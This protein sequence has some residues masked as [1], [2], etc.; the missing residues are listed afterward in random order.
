MGNAIQNLWAELQIFF[1]N[2]NAR[3]GKAF[4]GIVL[5]LIASALFYLLVRSALAGRRGRRS[6]SP[7]RTRTADPETTEHAAE[8]LA[9][10]LRCP[11]ITGREE[12][13]LAVGRILQE[14]YPLVA[15]TMDWATLPGGSIFLRWQGSEAAEHRPALMCAHLDVV[16]G[17]EG[18][19]A[20]EPF[21]GVR[22]NGRVYGRGAADCKGVIV[23]QMEAVQRLM[24]EGFRPRRDIYFAFGC[25][26]E[27]GGEK[28]AQAIARRME[29]MGLTFDLVLDEGGAIR[30]TALSHGG[31]Y[32]AAYI[33][34]GEKRRCEYRLTASCPGGHS[35][36]PGKRTVLVV[37]SE[38]ICRIEAAQ[39]RHHLIPIVREHLEAAM[40]TYPFHKRM[41]VANGLLLKLIGGRVFRDDPYVSALI[42]STIVPTKVDGGFTA[43]HVLP[44]T[45]GALLNARLL[46]GEQPEKILEELR[47][48]LA[49]LPVQVELI[50][51]GEES[52]ITSEKEPMYQLLCR[53]MDELYPRLQRVPTLVTGA[54]DARH[55]SNLSDCILRFSPLT[56]GPRGGGSDH[57]GDEF[58]SEH[59][60]GLAVEFYRTFLR[61]L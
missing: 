5:V 57:G 33:G 35:S 40:S 48:L 50:T 34:M 19:T 43:D 41:V 46:P 22:Q 55:Y 58:L 25:D 54:E 18:W 9:M 15:K 28:G 27:T 61:K 7:L 49:D 14:R 11:S 1:S 26:E 3:F 21:D 23:A 37:L 4:N 45:A 8:T 47:S 10:T 51:Q 2:F 59:S 42:R 16:P 60:L 52:F 6:L 29:Q 13:M 36:Q 53:T 44:S 17:G 56:L 24:E 38:A 31:S 32:T 20:C 39:P 12:E 30:E